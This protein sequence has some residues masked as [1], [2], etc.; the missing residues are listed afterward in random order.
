MSAS[1]P[2]E[3]SSAV[4]RSNSLACIASSVAMRDCTS[5]FMSCVSSSWEAICRCRSKRCAV[6]RSSLARSPLF[7][8]VD[9]SYDAC[10]FSESWVSS[11]VRLRSAPRSP[12]SRARSW[13]MRSI[14][15]V[16]WS[17]EPASR[18]SRFCR[19]CL[20]RLSACTSHCNESIFSNNRLSFFWAVS[21]DI[22]ASCTWSCATLISSS[23]VL[24]VVASALI[25]SSWDRRR[26][27]LASS[28]AS[29]PT[30]C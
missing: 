6:E 10:S 24:M 14:S 13:R 16:R 25:F 19:T 20:A 12:S 15:P 9:W 11:A 27:L 3:V 18:S 26:L 28:C 4:C 30:I 17:R 23:R 8:A 5:W 29:L 1:S 7:S 22:S 21:E 2:R